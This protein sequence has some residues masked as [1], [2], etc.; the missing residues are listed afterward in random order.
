MARTSIIGECDAVA[1][2]TATAID[3]ANYGTITLVIN[4]A[5]AGVLT[6]TECD[7]AA[8]SYTA[9]AAEDAIIPTIGAAGAYLAA[10]IGSKQ[11]VKVGLTGSGSTFVIVKGEKRRAE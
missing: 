1:G 5:A 8:G 11:Y 7:T 10:Y 3:T 4:A 6:L 2:A 9:V